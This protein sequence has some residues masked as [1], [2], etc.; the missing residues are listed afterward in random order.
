MK[1]EVN[2][3][4]TE[5]NG[6]HVMKIICPEICTFN[7]PHFCELRN[8]EFAQYNFRFGI[9]DPKNPQVQNIGK[10]DEIFDLTS[11]IL[12]FRNLISDS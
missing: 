4:K 5:A 10:I 11:A 6:F 12:N 2:A 1:F 9:N 7:L 8:F 3:L